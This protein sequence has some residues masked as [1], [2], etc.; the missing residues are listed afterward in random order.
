MGFVFVSKGGSNGQTDWGRRMWAE[1]GSSTQCF[2]SE[3][4]GKSDSEDWKKEGRSA[5]GGENLS[6]YGLLTKEAEE[7][8]PWCLEARASCKAPNLPFGSR[9]T[10]SSWQAATL[11][12]QLKSHCWRKC[13]ILLESRRKNELG[14]WGGSQQLARQ[15]TYGRLG[16][17]CVWRTTQKVPSGPG[18]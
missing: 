6:T 14:R 7:W 2:K 18:W 1:D 8:M 13:L 11:M 10:L 16:S 9:Q 3:V 17:H 4:M 12:S 15:Q 5:E